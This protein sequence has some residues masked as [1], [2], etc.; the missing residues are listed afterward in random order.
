MPFGKGKSFPS[1]HRELRD[2]QTG[3]VVHQLTTQPSISHHLYFLNRSFTPNGETVVLTSY[4]DGRANLYEL[5]FPDG[6][7]RQLTEGDG[8]HPFSAC[9]SH[10]GE[11]IFFTR[12]GSVYRLNR[13]TLAEDCL[14]RFSNAQLGECNLSGSGRW[15]VTAIRQDGHSG[16]AVVRTDGG[17]SGVLLHWPKTVIHP[18]FHPSDDNLIEFASDPA[19]R[20]HLLRRDSGAIECLYEHGNDEF[21]V[22]ETFLGQTGNLVFAVWPFTLR[23][24]DWQTREI[25]T[26]T[27]FN[28]W[29]IAPDPTGRFLLCDTNHPDIGIQLVEVSSGKRRTVCFPNSSSQGSQWRKSHYAL[30]E[31]WARAADQQDLERKSSLSW[32]EM[33]TD[34]V[35]GPQ[36]THPHP[37]W[38]PEGTH[39]IFTSDAT[40][41]PQ[42][43]A[44]KIPQQ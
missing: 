33:K 17:D 8:L 19:P 31:D 6:P 4:R 44:A 1:E 28:A 30:A 38:H 5:S 42:V 15:I 14:V 40:G 16:I 26:I 3:A 29:H 41:F 18:Q 9:L 35:Y 24:L 13:G 32:M 2:E 37:S 20:M 7:L 10:S 36:W 25:S 43:Y 11:E 23:Q 12:K 39:V 22:H 27:E 21:I 34:T